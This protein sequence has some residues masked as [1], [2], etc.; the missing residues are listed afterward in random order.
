MIKKR[1]IIYILLL[2]ALWFLWISLWQRPTNSEPYKIMESC[3]K[4]G[5]YCQ[6]L[7]LHRCLLGYEVV[8]ILRGGFSLTEMSDATGLDTLHCF[9]KSADGGKACSN[10]DQCLHGCNLHYGII[11][12]LCQEV[13]DG[14]EFDKYEC[15]TDKPGVCEKGP[16]WQGTP[17]DELYKLE[18]KTLFYYHS[19]ERVY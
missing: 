2:V 3:C 6:K 15:T 11:K 1:I 12:G 16:V 9:K 7:S 18:G 10:D 4:S 5:Q 19:K 14:K 17:N 8:C 13:E